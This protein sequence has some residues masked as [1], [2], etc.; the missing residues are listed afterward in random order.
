MSVHKIVFIITALMFHSNAI[1]NPYGPTVISDCTNCI[2][3]IMENEFKKPGLLIFANTNNVSSSVLRIRTELLKRINKKIKYTIEI[4][5]PRKEMEVCDR[6]IS[7]FGV[8]HVDHYVAIPSADYFIIIIDGYRDFSYLASRL[9]RSRIWN[10]FAKFI[11]LLFNFVNAEHVNIE[12]VEKILSCLFKFNVIDIV[13]AVPQTNNY[14]TAII[15]SWRPYDP[16]KYCG[17]FNE[18]AKNRLIE[19]NICENGAL[20]H[21]RDVFSNKLPRD[22][23]GC[24]L[25]ILALQ[26]QPYISNKEYDAN[27]EKVL[28]NRILKRYNM[29][30]KYEI[31]KGFRGEREDDGVWNGGLK[32]LVAKEGDILMGGIFP[33]FD[34]HEDFECSLTYLADTYTWVV[35]RAPK[36]P[37]WVSLL[38]IFKAY[39]W[40]SAVAGFVIC[41][42]SWRIIGELCGDSAYNRTLKHCFMNTWISIFGFVAYKRPVKESLRVFFVFLN[43]YSVLFLTAYQTKLFDTLTNPAYEYQ[44]QTVEELVDSGLQFGGFEELHDLFHNSS[45]PFD[46]YIGEQWIEVNNMTSAMIDVAVHRNFSVLCSRLELAHISAELPE[47]SDNLGNYKYYAFEG[48]MFSVPIEMVGLRGFP[49]MD[50][51]SSTITLFKQSGLNEGLRDMYATFNKRKRARLL[52]SLNLKEY[53]VNP[54]SGQHLQGGFLA[55]AFG[56]V[57]GTISL[58]IEIVI[59][60]KYIQRKLQQYK[61][62]RNK[63]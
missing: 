44:I 38:I 51:F 39:V 43:L 52:R 28:L 11:I 56:Y 45:D 19:E 36:L 21:S 12:H 5:S 33:D 40:Y 58:V 17:Y 16:P 57:G 1:I 59:N 62:R 26:R 9:T 46:F 8:L 54:L 63:V 30:A 22:M 32:R 10:P 37:A 34:V 29:T 4:M 50:E 3:N 61:E 14:R 2:I 20:K 31:I 24:V 13:I 60:S 47:L 6:D 18:T 15:Y 27:I 25:R 55:L 42:L 41:A 23:N 35:P 49:Y 53:D 7:K 48:D